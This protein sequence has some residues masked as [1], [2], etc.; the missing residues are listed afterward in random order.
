[1]YFSYVDLSRKKFVSMHYG[2]NLAGGNIGVGK[3]DPTMFL[4]NQSVSSS[5]SGTGSTSSS[6]MTST[7]D[8]P[9][10]QRYN[11]I[12]SSSSSPSSRSFGNTNYCGL[13]L[14]NALNTI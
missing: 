14:T 6:S 3:T 12:M 13:A 2:S 10:S 11:S 4:H 8:M 7:I 9:F 5:S 1:M